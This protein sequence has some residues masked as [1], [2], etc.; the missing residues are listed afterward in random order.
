MK[1]RKVARRFLCVLI[2]AM[3]ELRLW[4][5]GPGRALQSIA[6]ISR[7]V[8][9]ETSSIER[10]LLGGKVGDLGTACQNRLYL[11]FILVFLWWA[12][13]SLTTLIVVGLDELQKKCLQ[14][15]KTVSIIII[16]RDIRALIRQNLGAK[17][18]KRALTDAWG[19]STTD[20]EA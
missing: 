13:T 2:S 19:C 9:L 1:C 14:P 20:I 11:P 17:N 16:S 10:R 15:S 7:W 6:F 12:V 4:Y 5:R 18:T 8:L 3:L